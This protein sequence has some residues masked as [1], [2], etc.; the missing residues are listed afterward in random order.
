MPES[1]AT[2]ERRQKRLKEL[3][4]NAPIKHALNMEL[5][6]QSNGQA[7]FDMPYKADFDHALGG[8]H[9]GIYATL[10]DNAGWFTAATQVD[11]WVATVDFSMKLLRAAR[12]EALYSIGDILHVGRSLIMSEMKLYNESDRL[13]A[14]GQATFSITS[15]PSD[16]SGRDQFR[17]T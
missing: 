13:M 5:S 12:A 11:T 6:Y 16:V 14:I 10:L 8:I 7:R 15:L 9:G 4:D 2:L 17:N 1:L 3:F